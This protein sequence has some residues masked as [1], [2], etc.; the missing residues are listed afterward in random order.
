MRTSLRRT[1]LLAVTA[2]AM[3]SLGYGPLLPWSPVRPGYNELRGKRV[4]IVYPENASLPDA[5]RNPDALLD[6]AERFHRLSAPDY[7]TAVL[8]PDWP[9]AHRV[10]PR[11][12]RRG[13][14]AITLATG[15][16]IYVLP[17]IAERQLDP[18]EFVRHEL[19][20]AVLHQNQ[21]LLDATRI[22]EVQWLAEGIAVWFGNQRAYVSEVEFLNRVRT[23]DLE[24]YVDP[25]LRERLGK[26]F[27]MRF[28][29]VCWRHFNEYLAALDEERYWRFVHAV[30]KQPRAWRALFQEHFQQSLQQAVNAFAQQVRKE[31]PASP[32]EPA[33]PASE[34]HTPN[35]R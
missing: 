8:L 35:S 1:L 14:G 17:T 2:L 19:S 34:H 4:C 21:T 28:G 30:V 11:L 24:A 26:P 27:D 9:T 6:E 5:L 20:H 32:T 13:I 22:V 18:V 7:V 25:A 16:T 23:Q 31:G 15:R 33:A 29:Y 3:W 10:L 12:A